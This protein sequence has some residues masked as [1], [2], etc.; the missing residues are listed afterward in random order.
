MS[1]IKISL[2]LNYFKNIQDATIK[3]LQKYL[4]NK[5]ALWI[6]IV[7]SFTESSF[8]IVPPDLLLIPLAFAFPN[9]AL[10]FAFVTTLSS[11]AGGA[12]G[13]LL[14]YLI[15]DGVLQNL[16]LD[17]GY[18]VHFNKFKLFYDEYGIWAIFIAGFT[19]LP[20]KIAT[21]ASGVFES[22]FIMFLIVSF[23][24]RGLRFFLLAFI[25]KFYHAKGRA[26]IEKYFKKIIMISSI[27]ILLVASIIIGYFWFR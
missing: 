18:V 23:A 4:N 2:L 26:F 17:L 12:F 19:P 8:F 25:I 21:I 13:Y 16:I 3:W 27:I 15:Y 14:G 11:V 7:V 6:L 5:Y 24:S 9:R 22:N 1:I 20:Y 10:F